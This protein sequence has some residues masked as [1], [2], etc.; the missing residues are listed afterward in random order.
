MPD[1]E[2]ASPAFLA[3]KILNALLLDRVDYDAD[4]LRLFNAILRQGTRVYG[5]DFLDRINEV[6]V[7][8]RGSAYR[9]VDDFFIRPSKDLGAIAA[10]CVSHRKQ[11]A[12]PESWSTRMLLRLAGRGDSNEADLLSYL[13]FDGCYAKHLIELGR[14]DAAAERDKLEV[15]FTP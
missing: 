3:G 4:R 13:Y 2:I 15:F 12:A 5:A 6:I 7:R 9:V 10:E 1:A 14:A 11:R 8:E